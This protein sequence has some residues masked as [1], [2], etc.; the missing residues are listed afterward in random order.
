[1]ATTITG[2]TQAKVLSNLDVYN[3]TTTL[4][5]MYTVECNLTETPVS[6]LIIIIKQNGSTMASLASPAATQ[7]H[8]ELR[9]VLNCAIGDVISVTISSALAQDNQINDVRAILK[10]TPGTI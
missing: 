6:A 4:A 3:H 2:I 10:I 9:T 5:S 7:S 8:M 1:M